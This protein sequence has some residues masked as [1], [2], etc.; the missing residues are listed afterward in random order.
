MAVDAGAE[1]AFTLL[2]LRELILVVGGSATLTV[3]TARWIE[4]IHRI[5]PDLDPW[6]TYRLARLYVARN[7]GGDT[8]DLDTWLAFRPGVAPSTDRRYESAIS[9]GDIE[10]APLSHRWR[11]DVNSAV[12]VAIGT[13]RTE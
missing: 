2:A 12:I 13:G 6:T 9:S 8:K 11:S 1:A 4:T 5:A 10:R 3:A 7:T